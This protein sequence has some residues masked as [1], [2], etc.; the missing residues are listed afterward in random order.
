MSVLVTKTH[1]ELTNNFKVLITLESDI[2][3]NKIR[4]RGKN[5]KI[6]PRA[7]WPLDLR[8]L[9]AKAINQ[10]PNLIMELF[11]P[12]FEEINAC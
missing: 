1:I 4:Y 9:G 3:Q 8:E 10:G 11:M 2:K 7:T 12:V 6:S 5:K